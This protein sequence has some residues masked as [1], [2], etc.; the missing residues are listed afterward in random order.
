[1][2]PNVVFCTPMRMEERALRRGAPGLPDAAVVRTGMGQKRSVRAAQTLPL[3]DADAVAVVGVAGA[4]DP[5]LQPGDVVVADEVRAPD[6]TRVPVP[7]APFVAA[8]LRGA[9]H[10]VWTGPVTSAARVV[11]GASRD[12]LAAT[13]ALAVDMESAWLVDDKR[14]SLVVRVVADTAS[15]PLFTPATV[16]RMRTALRVLSEIAPALVAWGD[17]LEPRDVLLAGPR[18]FCAGV[19]RAIQ[20]VER[21]LEQRGAPVY[22]RKQIVHN[23]HVVRDLQQRGAVFVEELDEVPEGATVVF[24]AHGVAPMVWENGR[25]R[26]LDIIDATCPLVSKVHT[27]VRR[28]GDRG[29]TIVFIGH[30]GHEETEGTMGE[31]PD[32]TVLVETADDVAS[33]EVEDPERVSYLVQ[34]TLSAH[35]VEGVVEALRARFP[36]LQ[37]PP[38]D[39]ICYATTNRQDALSAVAVDSDVV[40]VIG[41]QNSSN[42]QRLVETS[43]RL[44]T[45]AYLVDD[46]HEVDLAW[47]VGAKT[48]GITAGA[49]APQALVDQVVDALAGLGRVHSRNREVVTEN[50]KFTLPKEVRT[51]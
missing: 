23:Q 37:A 9:G 13:G 2:R 7:G 28:F 51:A 26:G 45:P 41:S 18:S 4:L 24:S 29:D 38:T 39:D 34:T 14:P 31:R 25:T 44:G 49:S 27:E 32:R 30:A 22:V 17:A 10:R 6:G 5:R 19:E 1:M 33:L 43:T 16:G 46:V 8:H 15:E 36:K 20:V 21:A 50:V 48:V 35:E 42:S 11:S 47:L 3:Q 40:L 12:A